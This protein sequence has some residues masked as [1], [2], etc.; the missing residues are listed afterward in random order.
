MILS[1]NDQ[2]SKLTW[3]PKFR[4]HMLKHSFPV[5]VLILAF[6]SIFSYIDWCIWNSKSNTV[7]ASFLTLDTVKQLH[8]LS[9]CFVSSWS[10]PK[11]LLWKKNFHWK[12][13]TIFQK[14]RV[15]RNLSK[16][17]FTQIG[18]Y[19]QVMI[20]ALRPLGSPNY[21]LL[22]WTVRSSNSLNFFVSLCFLLYG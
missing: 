5:T 3:F 19:F 14:L 6:H 7:C 22:C 8:V 11:Q 10:S 15:S 20:S 13:L 2:C 21:F 17:F 1:G 9:L 4:S 12:G 16:F 18:W